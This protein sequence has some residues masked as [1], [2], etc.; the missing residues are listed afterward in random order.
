V[1]NASRPR[2]IIRGCVGD[3][4]KKLQDC[5]GWQLSH[6]LYSCWT[7]AVGRV[8]ILMCRCPGKLWSLA[9]QRATTRLASGLRPTTSAFIKEPIC[10]A[11]FRCLEFCDAWSC[12][13]ASHT[14]HE[15]PVAEGPKF[16]LPNNNVCF[17]PSPMWWIFRVDLPAILQLSAHGC[18]SA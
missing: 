10:L 9:S 3:V 12:M 6:L 5:C 11:G 14:N 16:N 17:T 8:H 18:L 4:L 13:L 7:R 15:L 1:Q 2:M